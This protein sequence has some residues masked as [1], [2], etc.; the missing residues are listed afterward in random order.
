[1]VLGRVLARL[2]LLLLLLAQG[3]KGGIERGLHCFVHAR[4]HLGFDGFVDASDQG[5]FREVAKVGR[6]RAGI[7]GGFCCCHHGVGAGWR[8]ALVCARLGLGP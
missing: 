5:F 1:M 7:N 3:G 8:L 6:V 4:A 2:L